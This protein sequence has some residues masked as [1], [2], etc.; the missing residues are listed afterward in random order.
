MLGLGHHP[1]RPRPT[2]PRL[3]GELLEDPRRLARP[4]IL[5]GGLRQLRR[6]LR[7]QA[8]ILGQPQDVI[9]LV[10]LAPR[11]QLFPAETGIAAHDNPHLRPRLPN[12]LH[13]AGEFLHA[14]RRPIAI[15]RAQPRA[16]QVFPTEDVQRE[17]AVVPIIAVKESPFLIPVQRIVRA[18]QV[19]DDLLRRL[20]VGLEKNLSQQ[21]VHRGKIQP[22][23]LVA[24]SLLHLR[25][26]QLQ[27]VQ[28]ALARQR[29]AL[30]AFARPALPVGS[31]F[32]ASTPSSGSRRNSS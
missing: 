11:H 28:R 32:S 1:P 4:L 25:C 30:I 8:I 27:P 16:Q 14:S 19:Q 23:L 18:V 20:A 13:Q 29:L 5:L 9:H 22:D 24:L 6:D 15:R 12:L 7:P 31:A 2:L 3:I 26:R 10:R 21:P 17:I